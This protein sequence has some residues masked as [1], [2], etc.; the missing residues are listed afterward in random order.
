MTPTSPPPLTALPSCKPRSKRMRTSV[1]TWAKPRHGTQLERSRLHCAIMSVGARTT[2]RPGL[3]TP[4]CSRN[5]RDPWY[6]TPLGSAA[7]V[8]AA[9][10]SK[11]EVRDALLDIIPGVPLQIDGRYAAYWADTCRHAAHVAGPPPA[12]GGGHVGGAVSPLAKQAPNTM[13]LVEAASHLQYRGFTT[14]LW[15]I[16][17]VVVVALPMQTQRGHRFGD[18]LRGGGHF[19]HNGA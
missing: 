2:R 12:C 8:H 16:L 10:Q 5:S 15:E 3:A 19:G 13:A 4:R 7:Y 17:V 6:Q 14:P 9:L 18:P 1:C 11:R